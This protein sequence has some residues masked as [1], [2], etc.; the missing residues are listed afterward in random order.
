[1]TTLFDDRTAAGQALARVLAA[2]H[3]PGTVVV[4]A[5]PRG[6]VPVVA[7]M[8]AAAAPGDAKAGPAP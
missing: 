7:A 4:L 3:W 2:R 1:M 5:L 6:G 8:A